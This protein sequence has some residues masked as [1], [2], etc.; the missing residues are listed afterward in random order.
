MLPYG[1]PLCRVDA[2]SDLIAKTT[3]HVHFPLPGY[4]LHKEK[5]MTRSGTSGTSA[6]S[7]SSW[8]MLHPRS[9]AHWHPPGTQPYH[10][11]S[12]I[13]LSSTIVLL[14]T[15]RG[16]ESSTMN[17]GIV[18]TVTIAL[19][20]YD[21]HILDESSSRVS[22]LQRKKTSCQVDIASYAVPRRA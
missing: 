3:N 2:L 11:D 14:T 17:E 4:F 16:P 19:V 9:N 8:S 20:R 13:N 1:S 7:W 15:C 22:W 21:L 10:V 12:T 18:R 6:C 5:P